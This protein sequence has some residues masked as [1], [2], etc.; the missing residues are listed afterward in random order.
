MK[1]ATV[2]VLSLAVTAACL[3]VNVVVRLIR[4]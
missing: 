2:F 1:G 3:V 4:Y